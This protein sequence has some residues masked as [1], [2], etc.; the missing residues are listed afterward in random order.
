MSTL[1]NPSVKYVIGIVAHLLLGTTFA[2]NGGL[3][4]ASFNPTSSTNDNVWASARL[5]NGQILIGGSFTTYQGQ[6]ANRIAL[7][8]EDGT[9]D[10]TFSI[11]GGFNNTVFSIV[12]QPDGNIL[13]GGDFTTYCGK[14]H[15]YIVRLKPT[16]SFDPYFTY[17]A[18]DFNAGVRAIALQHDGMFVVGGL[19]TAHGTTPRNRVARLKTDGTLDTSFNPGSGA[20]NFITSV[21][22]TSSGQFYVGGDFTTFNG[23]ICNRIARLNTNGSLDLTFNTTIGANNS[24]RAIAI[25][26]N[27]SVVVGGNFTQYN[28]TAKNRLARVLPNGSLD[29][30]FIPPSTTTINNT[31]YTILVITNQKLIVGGLFNSGTPRGVLRLL[32]NGSV[33]GTFN[34][35]ASMGLGIGT[36]YAVVT[37]FLDPSGR[38]FIGGKFVS[39]NGTTRNNIARLVGLPAFTPNDNEPDGLWSSSTKRHATQVNPSLTIYPNPSNGTRLKVTISG[40]LGDSPIHIRILDLQGRQTFDSWFTPTHSMLLTEL[41][42]RGLMNGVYLMNVE[43]A[44]GILVS[45]RLVIQQ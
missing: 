29:V 16:G 23:T 14:P 41:D 15:K 24:V 39:Y 27:G 17:L 36:L 1:N 45:S 7:L 25:D 6:P 32:T 38:I 44:D 13:V 10:P 11:G 12:V 31:I 3:L 18:D 26:I 21:V 37:A 28:G 22:R 4:D 2:Q 40:T 20:N 30:T 33:D 8:D 35:G 19:F 34:P 42:L 5:G 9:F 43:N